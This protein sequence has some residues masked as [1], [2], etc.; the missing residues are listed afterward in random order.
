MPRLFR[1]LALTGVIAAAG[2]SGA[3]VLANPPVV[4]PSPASPTPPPS[5]PPDP[6]PIA[7]PRDDGVHDRLTEWWYVT[8]HLSTPDGRRFGFE[9]VIFR[10]ERGAFPVTWA[11]H[12]A[13][14]DERGDRFLY[15]QRSEVGPQVDRA[16]AA[17]GLDLAIVGD[18][19][20]SGTT[21]SRTAWTMRRTGAG[22]ALDA[23]ANPD[24]VAVGGEPNGNAAGAGPPGIGPSAFGLSLA[25]RDS[26]PVLHGTGGWID[27]GPAGGSYYYSRTRQP[28]TGT[29][30]LGGERM[31]VSGISWFDHQWG[32]FISVGGGGWDWFA[33]NLGDGT[34]VTLSLV[35][36]ADGTY[37]LVYGTLVRPNGRV[38][39]LAADDF[40]VEPSGRWTSP[41]T[42]ATYP[43][44]WR[45]SLPGEGATIVLTPTVAAQE[46]DTRPTTG[47]TYWEG[48]QRVTLLRRGDIAAR[49][50]AGEA[51]VE[52]TGYAP[53]G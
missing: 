15:A 22:M 5:H 48:S 28:T 45:I 31:A 40:T 21:A 52:L 25:T 43:A 20:A 33:V 23:T 47:V 46:L 50:D 11:S 35:R 51:Y 7:F 39:H 24:E 36:A 8:G 3:P 4:R 18:P 12:L 14:T 32:D 2:C 16:A 6:Q 38:E 1:L 29:L 41:R 17:D 49:E 30:T 53:A 34:D 27:F 26:P 13:L 19:T 10:A 42:G 9:D 37:P 44:G